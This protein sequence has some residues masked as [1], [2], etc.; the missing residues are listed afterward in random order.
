M[1]ERYDVIFAGIGGM[2]V[3]LTGEILTRSAGRQYKHVLW[4]PNYT[5][6]Q[7]GAPCDCVVIVSDE[8]IYSPLIEQT[9]VVVVMSPS[10]LKTFEKRAKP[11]GLIITETH[12]LE[13]KV[14]RE[15]VKVMEMPALETAIKRGNRMGANMVNLGFLL[16][17]TKMVSL[18]H[19]KQSIEEKFSGRKEELASNLDLFLEGSKMGADAIKE[20]S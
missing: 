19:V 12:G 6:S 17:V 18:E 5:T 9:K 15:D 10:Q 11:G 4:L 8:E 3:L 16:G 1:Q 20:A 7:R 14:Q 2:G 13:D